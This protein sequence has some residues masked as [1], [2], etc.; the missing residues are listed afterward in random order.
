ML[1]TVSSCIATS[2][3]RKSFMRVSSIL[4]HQ[5]SKSFQKK[6]LDEVKA[7]FELQ[8]SSLRDIINSSLHQRVGDQ[9]KPHEPII[10]SAMILNCRLPHQSSVTLPWTAQIP[11]RRTIPSCKETTICNIKTSQITS[12]LPSSMSGS[13]KIKDPAESL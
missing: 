2:C 6:L 3:S 4:C 10:A 12:R 11:F 5:T 7:A 9:S 8:N 13:K 1:M